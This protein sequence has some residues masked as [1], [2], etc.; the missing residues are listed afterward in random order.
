MMV[1]IDSRKKRGKSN[2]ANQS[3]DAVNPSSTS[4][5]SEDKA[6][7]K[8]KARVQN[9]LTPAQLRELEVEKEKEVMKGYRRL[10]EIW[11]GMLA[12]EKHLEMEWLVEAEKLI[13]MFRE[14]RNLFVTSR[15]CCI[16]HCCVTLLTTIFRQIL[17]EGCFLDIVKGEGRLKLMKITW[18]L[19]SNLT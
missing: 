5:F 6:T 4:L 12:G 17:F 1:V 16:F 2:A 19:D 11:S 13:D 10:K 9:R 3:E 15:V 14:T 8:S 7:P 18:H